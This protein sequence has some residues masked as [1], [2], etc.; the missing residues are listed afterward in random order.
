[1]AR[2]PQGGAT[3]FSRFADPRLPEMGNLLPVGSVRTG[4]SVE[5][6]CHLCRQSTTLG[7]SDTRQKTAQPGASQPWWL[8]PLS[9]L[10]ET[11]TPVLS[12]VLLSTSSSFWSTPGPSNQLFSRKVIQSQ[13][14]SLATKVPLQAPLSNTA[15]A[16][17][18]SQL[19]GGSDKSG[20]DQQ[21]GSHRRGL[22]RGGDGSKD[23]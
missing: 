18:H 10:G 6:L 11:P 19:R 1:M 2:P 7:P 16:E 22:R 5:A 21:G 15:T 14:R 9:P 3:G 23:Y 8:P 20:L 4:R 12:S 17:V 13:I